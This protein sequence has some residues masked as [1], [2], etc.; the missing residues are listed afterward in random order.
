MGDPDDVLRS[1]LGPPAP[2]YTAVAAQ[3]TRGGAVVHRAV[4]GDAVVN[5]DER[6][7]LWDSALWDLA[8]LTKVVGTTAAMMALTTS[9]EV[10]LDDPLS[11]FGPSPD[12]A[13]TLRHLLTHRAGLAEWQPLYLGATGRDA[14][15]AL[16][17]R[18]PLRYAVDAGR[19]Y[20][21]LGL[22][23]VGG[24]VE[25][26]TGRRLDVAVRELVTGPLGL[27]ATGY[28][29]VAAPAAV[30]CGHGDDIERA[31]IRDGE[32]YP[33]TLDA[34]RSAPTAGWREVFVRGQVSDGN[35][36]HAMESVSGHA[37]LFSTLDDLARFGAAL[38]GESP[39]WSRP[40]RD[41][42]LTPGEDGQAVGFWWRDLGLGA[43]F[44]HPGFTGT[45]LLVDPARDIVA[46]LLTNR[47]HV[48]PP[49]AR[50][51]PDL[52][53]IWDAY[54]RATGVLPPD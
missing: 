39:A 36:Y 4:I 25:R 28:G 15:A 31:M 2:T 22:V 48:M 51:G 3:V 52:G 23:L 9:G 29:P 43:G 1:G 6:I 27:D 12:P 50:V 38:V 53:P 19:H 46:V 47:L 20:S 40:V 5:R 45:R 32:P 21:D 17:P 13:I 18:L 37:G 41:A 10:A 54:L 26:V 44:F 30:A 16:V 35:A 14:C 49:G 11:R 24:V 33:V 7:P 42:Y 34:V 8:S